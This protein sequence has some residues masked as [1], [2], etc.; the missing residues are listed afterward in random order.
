MES[1]TDWAFSWPIS[2]KRSQAGPCCIK[3]ARR[4]GRGGGGGSLGQVYVGNS[5]KHSVRDFGRYYGLFGRT[6]SR[7]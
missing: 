2:A 1:I 5:L 3:D 6:W 7:E 4:R